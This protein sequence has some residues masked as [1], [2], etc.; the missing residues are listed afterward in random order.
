[1]GRFREHTEWTVV[2]GAPSSGKTAVICELE[3]RGHRVVHEAA[4]AF[5]DSELRKGRRLK[6]IRADAA[7]FEAEIF[8]RK[9]SLESRLPGNEPIFFDRGLPDSIAYYRL[10]GLDV[11]AVITACHHYRYRNVFLFDRLGVRPDRVRV[12]NDSEA[13]V[14][15]TLLKAS[16]EQLGYPVVRVPLLPVAVRADFVSKHT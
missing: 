16:Y 3:R 1:M 10:A 8:R 13:A 9:M 6:D 15:D 4:R 2:T 11:D 5:I 12:E 14:L 7:A